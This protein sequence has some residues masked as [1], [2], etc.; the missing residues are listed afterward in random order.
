M[1]PPASVSN[2][3]G[4]DPGSPL[5]RHG[6]APCTLPS[7]NPVRYALFAAGQLGVM[8]LARF[9]FQWVLRFTGGDPDA[10]AQ[11][12]FAVGAVGLVFLGFRIFDGVTD[13]LAG[14]LSDSWVRRGRERRSLLWWAFWLPGL[15]L[16]LIFAPNETMATGLRWTLLALGM[17]VFF[18]GYTLYAIPYWSLIADYSGGDASVRGRLSNLL[19]AGTLVATAL[20]FVISPILV[21]RLGFLPAAL[22]FAA[23]C[24]ALMLLPYWAA[25]APGAVANDDEAERLSR[26]SEV[27]NVSGMASFLQA[28]RHRRFVAVVL[29]FA[30]GQMAFSVMT[31]AAPYIAVQLLGGTLGDVAKLLGPFLLTAIPCFAIVPRLSRRI[32]WERLVL[33]SSVALS[34]VYAG[35]GGLGAGWVGTPMT[36]AMLMFAAAGPMSAVL[37]GLEGEAVAACADEAEGQVTS[38]YFGVFNLVVKGL[39]GVAMALTGTLAEGIAEHG[40]IAVRAMGFCGGALLLLGLL[41]YLALRPRTRVSV[42]T[43]A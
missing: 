35:T 3:S 36:T 5:T 24:A 39:N 2:D 10:G 38:I 14:A 13:P 16:A 1:S 9:F 6:Q 17:L 15:G 21:E 12:L 27:A 18:I 41:T 22:C 7:M 31:A 40:V 11:P 20:G 30:G 32:G 42:V 4:A 28:F 8:A 29:L 33:L 34:L 19:G 26:P 37:L 25:P 23:P 43:T